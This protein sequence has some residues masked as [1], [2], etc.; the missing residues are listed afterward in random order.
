MCSSDLV[1]VNPQLYDAFGD[2]D[3]RA[4]FTIRDEAEFEALMKRLTKE[5]VPF[6]GPVDLGFIQ[7]IQCEDP[8]GIHVEF[9]LKK[10]GYE[11]VLAGEKSRAREN[12]Q[13]WIAEAA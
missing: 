13:A 11:D 12:L 2:L 5:G 4:A 9:V 6:T 1:W 7:S 3:Q 8:S 10:P